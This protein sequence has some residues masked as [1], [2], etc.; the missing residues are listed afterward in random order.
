MANLKIV[1]TYNK[2]KNT[3]K[4]TDTI[5]DRCSCIQNHIKRKSHIYFYKY[6]RGRKL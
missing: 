4:V 5:I 1:I 2:V 6:I 3:S